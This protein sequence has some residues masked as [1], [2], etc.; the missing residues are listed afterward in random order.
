MMIRPLLAVC[1]LG[2]ALATPGVAQEDPLPPAPYSARLLLSTESVWRGFVLSEGLSLRSG[3]AFP[4]LTTPAPG[5][6]SDGLQV[7]LDGWTRIAGDP[8]TTLNDQ[9]AGTLRY[10]R[11]LGG[12]AHPA[13]YV[14]AHYRAYFHAEAAG[15]A[16][17]VTHEVGVSGAYEI[18][19]PAKGLQ[20]FVLHAQGTHSVGAVGGTYT[21]GG[22]VVAL[23][24]PTIQWV[25]AV[26]GTSVFLSDYDTR[27]VNREFGYAGAELQVMLRFPL[28]LR[29]V[30]AGRA[31]LVPQAGVI[32][33]HGSEELE[34]N[35]VSGFV[36][37]EAGF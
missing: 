14:G 12:G 32:L 35:A 19:N 28:V 2:L 1:A 17:D 36:G 27:E 20:G 6:M 4:L 21:Q 22:L 13:T 11:H 3:V 30:L 16:E 29:D 24:A 23:P 9:Y 15:L 18:R 25:D 5:G 7:E 8:G 34:R 33:A 37:L 10:L 31:S 26:V